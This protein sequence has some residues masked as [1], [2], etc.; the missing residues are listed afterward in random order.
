MRS[1]GRCR[2]KAA[3]TEAGD[4]LLEVTSRENREALAKG[5]LEARE[6]CERAIEQI[7]KALAAEGEGEQ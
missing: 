1:R 7:G 4:H 3:T 2:R 5:V 6:H